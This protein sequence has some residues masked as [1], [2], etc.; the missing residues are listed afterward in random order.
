MT[1]TVC[2]S[3]KGGSGTTVVAAALALGSAIDSLARRSRRRA[4]RR[5]RRSRAERTGAQRLVRVRRPDEAVLDLAAEIAAGDVARAQ[6]AG[7]DPATRR[8]GRPSR[9]SSSSPLDV[10][11]DAGC[12]RPPPALLDDRVPAACS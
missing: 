7:G 5:P 3:A 9:T 12:G 11:V 8:A 2:W 4:A 1:L 6:G 10:V